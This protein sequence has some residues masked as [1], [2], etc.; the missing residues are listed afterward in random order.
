MRLRTVH[1]FAVFLSVA[2]LAFA[3]P[4]RDDVI[5]DLDAH[6]AVL[7]DTLLD[8][9]IEHDLGYVEI[10]AANPGVDPWLPGEGTFVVLPTMHVLPTAERRGI[11]I[12][13]AEMRLYWFPPLGDAVTMPIGIGSEGWTSALG[14]T[15]I[16]RK[17]LNPTWVPPASVRAEDPDLPAS[18][19]PG[20]DNP[21]GG[22]ALDLGWPAV[23]LH[24]TNRPYGIG[25]RVSHG[26]FRL[27]NRNAERL[28]REIPV[29]TRVTVVD[30]P[31]KTGWRQGALYLEVHPT[32]AQADELEQTGRMTALPSPNVRDRLLEMVAGQGDRIDWQL[33]ERVA[34]ERS[35][36][37]VRVT[38]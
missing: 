8:I 25:R 7:E 30:E 28:Y 23:V 14:H 22:H 10:I 36:V 6:V 29:G 38:R 19:P 32:Q 16:V 4:P 12:N 35:G 2:G 34:R 20:P 18:V 33:V 17:R 5:G 26:C 31:V 11:V 3:A 13:L 37:P 15:T 24:G 21:L 1:L 27:S 9:A